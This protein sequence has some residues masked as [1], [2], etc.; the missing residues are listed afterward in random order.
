[1]NYTEFER[2][3]GD[4]ISAFSCRGLRKTMK[5]FGFNVYLL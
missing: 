3:V 5:Y 1:M 2:K 4:T